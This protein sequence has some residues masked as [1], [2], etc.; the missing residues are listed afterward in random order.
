MIFHCFALSAMP[1]SEWA[2]WETIYRK[3]T[4]LIHQQL[5]V[6]GILTSKYDHWFGWQLP[7]TVKV[8]RRDFRR[9]IGSTFLYRAGTVE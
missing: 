5:T 9:V 1:G 4:Q 3:F 6:T 2:I 7:F 8:Q